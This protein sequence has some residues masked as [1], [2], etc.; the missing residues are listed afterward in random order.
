MFVF[1]W[2]LVPLLLAFIVFT[3]INE[4][5]GKKWIF[6]LWFTVVAFASIGTL[7]GLIAVLSVGSSPNGPGAP[8][9]GS[10][11]ILT[12]A[13][14]LP[15]PILLFFC[16]KYRP[17]SQAFNFPYVASTVAAVI[18]MSI[19]LA[20]LFAAAFLVKTF[21]IIFSAAA[22]VFMSAGRSFEDLH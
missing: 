4:E 22:K 16:L 6:A 5:R 19:M 11:M 13:F 7:Y 20:Y 17:G 9:E 15:C 18:L 10:A 3:T 21:G 14:F 1:A 2:M 8:L 12:G